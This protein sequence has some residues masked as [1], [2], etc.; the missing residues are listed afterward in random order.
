[1]KQRLLWLLFMIPI[2]SGCW[3]VN[4]PERMYY[5][6]GMGIDYQDGKYQ[7]YA[8]IIDFS[9]IAKTEQPI[10]SGIQA[11]IG[12]ASGDN[13]SDAF[14]K[15][16]RSMD[17]KIFWGQF[18]YMVFSEEAL[19][20]GRANT[21]INTYI[22]FFEARYQTWIYGTKDSVKDVLLTTPII[23]KAISLS[24]LSDPFNSYDQDS[25]IKPINFRK[26]ILDLDEPGH[27]VNV[28]LV[29]VIENWETKEGPHNVT[30]IAG[31]G[32]V[33][34]ND[35]KGLIEKE[36]AKGLQW[37]TSGMVR[38]GLTI[39]GDASDSIKANTLSVAIEKLDDKVEP[40]VENG[41]VR[42]DVDIKLY[43]S[44][45]TFVDRLTEEEIRKAVK[46]QVEKEI[47]T[48]Y[49]A[50]LE[51]DADVYR[52]SE[53]LYRKDVKLWKKYQKDGKVELTNDSIRNINVHIEKVKAGRKVYTE[54]IE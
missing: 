4:E 27:E 24:K 34:P 21:I 48:T 7:L 16:Y 46:K 38:S 35:I 2:L 6:H 53:S 18:T 28:P 10:P 26:F 11:E 30:E 15:L 50:G 31:V 43:V 33:S 41:K 25:F 17:E 49:E 29:S 51:I 42:F 22:R 20:D 3:D 54:T 37:M 32:V 13:L 9:K 47:R 8:Q 36:K 44:V 19:K 12:H 14:Y 45:T 1:M 39:E 5:I 52:L 40:V 23:N